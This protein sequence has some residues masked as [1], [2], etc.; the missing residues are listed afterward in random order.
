MDDEIFTEQL[1]RKTSVLQSKTG[2]GQG[3][4]ASAF[5]NQ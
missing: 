3:G 5:S 2:T 4:D 1:R